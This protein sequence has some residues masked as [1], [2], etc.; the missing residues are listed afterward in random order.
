MQKNGFDLKPLMETP[1]VMWKS[2]STLVTSQQLPKKLLQQNWNWE[3]ETRR[4]GCHQKWQSSKTAWVECSWCM[5]SPWTSSGT[6]L[7]WPYK[8][9]H[10]QLEQSVAGATR[11]TV[12]TLAQKHVYQDQCN[13]Q[14]GFPEHT[15]GVGSFATLSL[16]SGTKLATKSRSLAPFKVKKKKT[17]LSYIIYIAQVATFVASPKLQAMSCIY[18]PRYAMA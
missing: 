18:H 15:H 4:N 13:D 5:Q 7:R 16:R 9:Y 3:A 10:T 8:Q 14:T 17:K 12:L 11:S 2:R 6:S 1:P